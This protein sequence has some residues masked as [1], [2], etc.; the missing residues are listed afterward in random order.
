MLVQSQ[1]MR[2]EDF[3]LANHR[4]T[5]DPIHAKVKLNP[6]S[7]TVEVRYPSINCPHLEDTT[8]STSRSTSRL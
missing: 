1:R 6:S 3:Y 2:K 7:L 5:L 4:I 8:C